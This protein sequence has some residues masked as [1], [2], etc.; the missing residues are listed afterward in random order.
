MTYR[1]HKDLGIILESNMIEDEIK[2]CEIELINLHHAKQMINNHKSDSNELVVCKHERTESLSLTLLNKKNDEDIVEYSYGT[3]LNFYYG[4]EDNQ[5]NRKRVVGDIERFNSEILD[6][7]NIVYLDEDKFDF[8][9]KDNICID[10]KMAL[11]RC[12]VDNRIKVYPDCEH[13]TLEY[14]YFRNLLFAFDSYKN[15]KNKT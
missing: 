4:F 2:K 7:I 3:N 1:K 6:C 10:D 9:I 14:L 15:I 11:K 8:E 12:F 13:I 5:L